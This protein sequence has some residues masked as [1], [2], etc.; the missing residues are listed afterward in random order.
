[1]ISALIADSEVL[2]RAAYRNL[3]ETQCD[4]SVACETDN[5]KKLLDETIK[6]K[7]KVVITD[8]KLADGDGFEFIKR[9]KRFLPGI[10]VLILTSKVDRDLVSV[11]MRNGASAFVWKCAPL[12]DLQAGLSASCTG[13]AFISPSLTHRMLDAEAS[14]PHDRPAL[15]RRQREVMQL[16]GQGKSTK[17]IAAL[18]GVS[19]KTVETHRARLMQALGVTNSYALIHQAVRLNGL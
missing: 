16:I 2:T 12:Q 3:L 5:F 19:V 11:A 4:V 6:F 1:M 7:P 9:V 15:P 13:G 17:Q 18:L 10:G 14:H 8:I